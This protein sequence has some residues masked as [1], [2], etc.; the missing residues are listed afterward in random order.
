M[1]IVNPSICICQ[2]NTLF[3]IKS[4]TRDVSFEITLHI[5]LSERYDFLKLH[6]SISMLYT[7]TP[8][9]F[10]IYKYL[11][12]MYY[13]YCLLSR[14]VLYSLRNRNRV[15]ICAIGHIFPLLSICVDCTAYTDALYLQQY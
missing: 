6:H 9:L 4:Y 3:F 2:Y 13:Y 12:P 1:N 8:I 11:V 5:L 15:K 7:Q 14:S 10:L